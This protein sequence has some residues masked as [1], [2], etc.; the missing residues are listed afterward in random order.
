MHLGDEDDLRFQARCLTSG[1]GLY[2]KAMNH[3]LK[4]LAAADIHAELR[5]RLAPITEE[6]RHSHR[7]AEDR[8]KRIERLLVE[9]PEVVTEFE[10]AVRDHAMM[11]LYPS[12]ERSRIEQ[13]YRM[14]KQELVRA[15]RANEQNHDA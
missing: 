7:N 4:E 11:R 6:L 5:R 1:M 12:H 8:I 10:E 13:E 9:T 14:R 3:L 2:T 15:L